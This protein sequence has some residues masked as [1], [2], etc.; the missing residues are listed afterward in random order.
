MLLENREKAHGSTCLLGRPRKSELE[1]PLD[2]ACGCQTDPL[3]GPPHSGDA[4]LLHL[5]RP[6]PC[7]GTTPVIRRQSFCY[8][9]PCGKQECDSAFMVTYLVGPT[10]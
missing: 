5:E 6:R 9:E 3:I 1:A 4:G 7:V 2:G 10:W 8:D